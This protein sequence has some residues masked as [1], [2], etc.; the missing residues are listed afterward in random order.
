LAKSDTALNFWCLSRGISTD[1]VK[2]DEYYP[3]YII[4][5]ERFMKVIQYAN[6]PLN[7]DEIILLAETCGWIKT[8]K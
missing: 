3:L 7:K 2:S 5:L 4:E 1:Q 8:Y 6:L